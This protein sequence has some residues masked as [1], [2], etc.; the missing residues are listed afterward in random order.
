SEDGQEKDMRGCRDP[1]VCSTQRGRDRGRWLSHTIFGPAGEELGPV[2]MQ[3]GV[4][5]RLGVPPNA[6]TR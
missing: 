1:Q 5:S 3:G 6:D 2:P 4:V